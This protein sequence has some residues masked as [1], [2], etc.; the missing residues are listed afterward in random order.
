MSLPTLK[1][2]GKLVDFNGAPDATL[3]SVVPIDHILN[4][5]Q[6]RYSLTGIENRVLVL[7]SETASG[8]STLFPPELYKKFKDKLELKKQNIICTQPRVLT[9][10]QNVEEIM[11]HNYKTFK[12]GDTIGWLTKENKLST[13]KN[14][15]SLISATVGT[16]T[17]QL[18]T[19]SDDDIMKKYKF[20]LIDETHERNLQTDIT[21]YMLKNLLLRNAHKPQCPFVVLMSATFEHQLFLNYFK[22]TKDNFIWCRGSTFPIDEKWEWTGEYTKTNYITAAAE[23]VARI[24][25][26]NPHDDPSSADI[27]VFMPGKAEFTELVKKLEAVRKHETR[28][29]RGAFSILQIDSEAVNKDNLDHQLTIY[30]PVHKHKVTVDDKAYVPTRRVIISTNIA[31]TGL[32]LKNL[33]YVVDSGYNKSS[34]YDPIH[35]IHSVISK[36][37]PQSRIKQ[38]RGRAGRNAA[39]I[40]VPLYPKYVHARLQEFQFPE[41]LVEDCMPVMMDIIQEQIKMKKYMREPVGFS[42]NDIDMIDVP[43]VDML[44]R[45]VERL[46]SMGFIAPNNIVNEHDDTLAN[47]IEQ[48]LIDSG[49]KLDTRAVGEVESKV[50]D[51][52]F[53]LTPL[54][55]TARMIHDVSPASARAVLAAYFWEASVLDMI[56]IAVYIEISLGSFITRHKGVPA[57]I[58]WYDIYKK[59]LPGFFANRAMVIRTRMLVSD[60]FIDGLIIFNSIKQMTGGASEGSDAVIRLEEWCDKVKLKKETVYE[61]IKARDEL[62]NSMINEGFDVFKFEDHALHNTTKETLINTV[63]KL[64]HCIYD[65]Y[66]DNL[67]VRK[68]SDGANALSTIADNTNAIRGGGANGKASA[69][70]STHGKANG[71]ASASASTANVYMTRTGQVIAKPAFYHTASV[72]NPEYHFA[73]NNEPSMMIYNKLNLKY[74]SSTN[75]YTVV[76]DRV[77]T[78]DSFVSMD[79]EFLV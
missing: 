53:V 52:T 2:A 21:I 25:K 4:W 6:A 47:G 14:K 32:T 26:E 3:A 62:I 58:D 77:C 59:G 50:A 61:F 5:F 51:G 16:L 15:P 11:V 55:I 23:T 49:V 60:D 40:F 66:R 24:V 19:R 44:V 45:A 63:V 12:K 35:D 37:A 67:I 56:T 22:L 28:E 41:I 70:T 18:R 13:D 72:I 46:Y 54:G 34:E 29:G 17:E 75:T 36:P 64:K 71:I 10:I 78:L 69:N 8:K 74:S 20:I 65:G 9:A 31:E 48:T 68:G 1:I 30:V 73:F 79:P 42:I 33:K 7:K 76:A 57:P 39:G 27:L 43:G 38:R